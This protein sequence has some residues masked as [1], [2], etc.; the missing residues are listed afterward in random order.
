MKHE[1]VSYLTHGAV[2]SRGALS[3]AHALQEAILAG[4]YGH[5]Q[6]LPP[7]RQLAMDYAASR[8]TIRKALLWLEAQKV[9]ER[10]AGSGTYVIYD[11]AETEMDI[12]DITSPLELIEVRAT[13]EPQLARLAV[14]H[15]TARD[16][17]KLQIWLKALQAA[18]DEDNR[19]QYAVADEQFHLAL[20]S[21]TSN[22]L[23]VWLYKQI[24]IIKTHAQWGQMR[25]QILS[26]ANMMLYNDQHAAVLVAIKA[27]DAAAAADAMVAHMDK[28]RGDLIGAH[29]G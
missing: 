4:V 2:T 29:S 20:A 11:P 12:A 22:P 8:T 25:G 6:Q 3:I 16:I 19:E 21:A 7:E 23:M 5:R 17:D 24:N 18:A 1:N 14:L 10:R 26:R 9:V 27:R 28:A 15:A 13:I